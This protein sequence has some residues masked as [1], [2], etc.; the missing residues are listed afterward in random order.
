MEDARLR[1]P[2]RVRTDLGEREVS[3]GMRISVLVGLPRL[4]F[5]SRLNDLVSGQKAL[6]SLDWVIRDSGEEWG[7]DGHVKSEGMNRKRAIND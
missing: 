6:P 7:Q 4:M 2:K 5:D 3:D 1:L